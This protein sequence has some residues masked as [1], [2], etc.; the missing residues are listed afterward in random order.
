MVRKNLY[1]VEAIVGERVA[2]NG[3]PRYLVKWEGY[4][5][6]ESTWEPRSHIPSHIVREWNESKAQLDHLDL[7]ESDDE[8]DGETTIHDGRRSTE[9][10]DLTGDSDDEHC[11]GEQNDG[12]GDSD[13]EEG[14]LI[15]IINGGDDQAQSGVDNGTPEPE[16]GPLLITSQEAVE[17]VGEWRDPRMYEIRWRPDPQT[18]EDGKRS[19]HMKDTVDKSLVEAWDEMKAS[20]GTLADRFGETDSDVDSREA[21]EAERAL[22]AF[23]YAVTDKYIFMKIVQDD[24]EEAQPARGDNGDGDRTG[25]YQI[26]DNDN[27]IDAPGED[28]EMED[29]SKLWPAHSMAAADEQPID[30][31]AEITMFE[32]VIAA[33][34]NCDDP[35]DGLFGFVHHTAELSTC[36]N[37]GHVGSETRTCSACVNAAVRSL[38]ALQRD[39]YANGAFFKI[40]VPCTEVVMDF[41]PGGL[42]LCTCREHQNCSWCLHRSTA[43]LAQAKLTATQ[44]GYNE[45]ICFHCRSGLIGLEWVS[46]CASCGGMTVEFN[47]E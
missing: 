7:E 22:N 41:Y 2:D 9:V 30:Q 29:V 47:L 6:E 38:N 1:E 21:D 25:D 46:Q 44:N 43:V 31:P 24:S 32:P 8:D 36:D 27:T 3:R 20:W 17:I 5:P 26:D 13:V 11:D 16:D 33:G 4:K 19:W 42:R 40:C 10:I 12:R 18:G 34:D 28:I 35:S 15:L 14:R 23:S 39:A 45:N 37:P